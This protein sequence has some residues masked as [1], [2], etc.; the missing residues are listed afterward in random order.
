MDPSQ[1]PST[2]TKA[3]QLAGMVVVSHILVAA[4]IAVLVYF[5]AVKKAASSGRGQPGSAVCKAETGVTCTQSGLT[6]D[7]TAD[8]PTTPTAPTVHGVTCQLNKTNVYECHPDC[9][10]LVLPST[11]PLRSCAS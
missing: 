9:D 1:Q 4:L 11:T 10:Q 3:N 8:A 7:C 2:H 5:L 6:C